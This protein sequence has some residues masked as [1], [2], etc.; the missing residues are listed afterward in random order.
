MNDFLFGIFLILV[1]LGVYSWL[2][3]PP[4]SAQVAIA[5]INY[6]GKVKGSESDEYI[7]I[8]NNGSTPADLSGWRI[9]AG[10]DNQVFYFPAGTIL[11]SGTRIRV[12]TNEIHPEWGGFSFASNRPIW[13]NKGDEG[14]LYDAAGNL[15]AS[16]RY[17]S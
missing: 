16:Q 5:E 1:I 15:V 4:A 2:S 8:V 9:N 12:Y 10:S 6:K 17:S 11:N 7:E 13:N 3:T 14:L